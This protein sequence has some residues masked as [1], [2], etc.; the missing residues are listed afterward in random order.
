MYALTRIVAKQ[1]NLAVQLLAS[2]DDL[3]DYLLRR[4]SPLDNGWRH[5]LLATRLDQLLDGECGLTV[6]DG[7]VELL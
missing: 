3:H 5:D 2:R 1:N 7:H 6:K 4:P